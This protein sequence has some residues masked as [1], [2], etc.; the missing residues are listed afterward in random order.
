MAQEI[1]YNKIVDCI[2]NI[3]SKYFEEYQADVL[4]PVAD[5]LLIPIK[6]EPKTAPAPKED[7][8]NIS[9]DVVNFPETEN[10]TTP[11]IEIKPFINVLIKDI[12]FANYQ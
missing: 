8:R 4:G 6:R 3:E 7:L 2:G 5:D 12:N 9:F 11:E 10:T 1:K